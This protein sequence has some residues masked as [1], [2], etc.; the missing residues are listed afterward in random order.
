MQRVNGCYSQDDIKILTPEDPRTRL[1][2]RRT[3]MGHLTRLVR[4]YKCLAARM[5]LPDSLLLCEPFQ[6]KGPGPA[7][8]SVHNGE[9][10]A[11]DGGISMRFAFDLSTRTD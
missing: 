1:Q 5:R 10:R 9:R 4:R 3:N 11:R 2:W 8:H 7:R 6:E